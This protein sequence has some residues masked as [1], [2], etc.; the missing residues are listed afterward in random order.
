MPNAAEIFKEEEGMERAAEETVVAAR[1][2]EAVVRAARGQGAWVPCPCQRAKVGGLIV[3]AHPG[4]CPRWSSEG[5]RRLPGTQE[6]VGERSLGGGRGARAAGP[7]LSPL[8]LSP[9]QC[10][11]VWGESPD[12]GGEGEGPGSGG[13]ESVLR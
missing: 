13:V 5:G 8:P 9:E 1:V 3:Q 6:E 12:G 2:D 7:Y 11:G 10:M 4:G